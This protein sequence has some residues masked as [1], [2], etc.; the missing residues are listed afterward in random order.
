MHCSRLYGV[1]VD[2]PLADSERAVEFWA[3]ALGAAA[4]RGE[5]DDPYV[6]LYEAAGDVALSQRELFDEHA[7]S[8]GEV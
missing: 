1:F 6:A 3:E 5:E 8:W 7:K 4:V 2:T